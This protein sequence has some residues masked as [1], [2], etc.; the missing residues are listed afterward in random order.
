[1]SVSS[2]GLQQLPLAVAATV[3]FPSISA[4][5]SLVAVSRLEWPGITLPTAVQGHSI[6]VLR[7]SSAHVFQIY[8]S[9]GES[10]NG[11]ATDIPMDVE[12]STKAVAC[13]GLVSSGEW[14]CRSLGR[15]GLQSGSTKAKV[16]SSLNDTVNDVAIFSSALLDGSGAEVGMGVGQA[17]EVYND[18][19]NEFEV[20][21]IDF[22]ATSV[23]AGSEGGKVVLRTMTSGSVEDTIEFSSDAVKTESDIFWPIC[24]SDNAH[25]RIWTRFVDPLQWWDTIV[26]SVTFDGDAVSGM[27]SMVPGA[28]LDVTLTDSLDRVGG[29]KFNEEVLRVNTASDMLF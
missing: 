23:A 27:T 1:M 19:G 21:S 26:E 25:W 5:T 10:L 12:V 28:R 2:H 13:L 14:I 7:G 24:T 29:R 4:W 17:F 6:T 9:S 20:G 3:S 8:P 22:V 18:G 11:L 15:D 16:W